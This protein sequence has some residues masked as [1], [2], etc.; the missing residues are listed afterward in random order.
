[1]VARPRLVVDAVDRALVLVDRR[2]QARVGV[3]RVDLVL[4]PALLAVGQVADV[5]D[6]AHR[7]AGRHD[8]ADRHR[9]R[10]QGDARVLGR[11]LEQDAQLVLARQEMG[12][13]GEALQTARRLAHWSPVGFAAPFQ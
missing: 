10:A 3:D 2:G 6:R 11:G 7:V 4:G 1:M 5:D 13:G 8:R 9:R 12:H